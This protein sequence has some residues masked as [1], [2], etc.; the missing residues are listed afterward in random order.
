[1]DMEE[2]VVVDLEAGLP[3][4]ASLPICFLLGIHEIYPL[5]TILV[6]FYI[7]VGPIHQHS[8]VITCS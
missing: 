2:L 6:I 3:S 7:G 8:F 5:N 4:R 1:M